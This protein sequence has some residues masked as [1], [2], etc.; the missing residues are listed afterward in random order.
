MTRFALTPV[1]AGV[2]HP[3]ASLGLL[4]FGSFFIGGAVVYRRRNQG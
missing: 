3:G 1:V 2:R 4:L